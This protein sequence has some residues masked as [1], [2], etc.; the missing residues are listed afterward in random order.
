VSFDIVDLLGSGRVVMA[1]SIPAAGRS[2]VGCAEAVALPRFE[3]AG[4]RAYSIWSRPA[5][6]DG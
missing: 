5:P 2:V 6:A 1:I 4:D 3:H